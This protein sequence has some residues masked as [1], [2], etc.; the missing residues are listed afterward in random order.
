MDS[1]G[2]KNYL[3]S[4]GLGEGAVKS[5]I[6]R[7]ARIKKHEGSLDEHF[8]KDELYELIERLN[9]SQEDKTS[10]LQPRHK[11]PI[12]GKKGF[13]SIYDGT[14]SLKDAAIKY[15]DFRRGVIPDKSYRTDAARNSRR[16]FSKATSWPEWEMPSDEELML[17]AK[18]SAKHVRFLNPEIVEIIVKDN[19]KHADEWIPALKN[20]GVNV[21]E[22]LWEGSPCVFPGV[23]R[24]SGAKEISAFRKRD[25]E[26]VI[27]A[28]AIDDNSYPK[29]LWAFIFLGK[30]FGNF[31]PN[32][33]KLAHLLDHKGGSRIGEEVQGLKIDKLSGL[34]TSAANSAYISGLLMDPT[35][36]NLAIRNLIQRKAEQLYGSVCNILPDGCKVKDDVFKWEIG[37]FEWVEPVGTIENVNA[38]LGFRNEEMQRL[39]ETSQES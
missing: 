19:E 9:Y 30:K 28:L 10:G 8:S 25:S 21:D 1:V 14:A 12:N 23:R 35:D 26:I 3:F 7:A 6:S 13:Q 37:E 15:R 17:L 22:Y 33:Y 4:L 39:I 11:V 27:D 18:S 34:Y 16:T 20:A 36:H 2:F 5:T 24:H 29:Q 38:F 32:G 31:G